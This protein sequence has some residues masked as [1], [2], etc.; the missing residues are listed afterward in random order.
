[1]E[2]RLFMI[3]VSRDWN[4][5]IHQMV[6]FIQQKFS[7]SEVLLANSHANK[8]NCIYPWVHILSW[9]SDFLCFW[10]A[11]LQKGM[12]L[13]RPA[14]FQ[15]SIIF[16][17]QPSDRQELKLNPGKFQTFLVLLCS[18]HDNSQLMYSL[19]APYNPI[20]PNSIA[21]NEKEAQPPPQPNISSCILYQV[22]ALSQPL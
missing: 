9:K 1:M 18:V 22:L 4:S 14:S 20:S 8:S 5:W 7:S 3:L 6:L 2:D 11:F 13:G 21:E 12:R 10:R 16:L 15:R 19:M 17:I